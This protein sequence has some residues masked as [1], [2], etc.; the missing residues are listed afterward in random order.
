VLFIYI[1]KASQLLT[2]HAHALSVEYSDS[3]HATPAYRHLIRHTHRGQ[4]T[5][6]AI[7]AGLSANYCISSLAGATVTPQVWMRW[8]GSALCL[9]Y[10]HLF[11]C[12]SC[13]LVLA[14]ITDAVDCLERFVSEATW[15][16]LS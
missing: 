2:T 15:Y 11:W 1:H 6:S 9:S 8:V 5:G 3:S 16:E 7:A 4:R 10:L 13:C 12:V 14:V